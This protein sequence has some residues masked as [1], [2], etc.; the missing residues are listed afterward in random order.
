MPKYYVVAGGIELLPVQ[1]ALAGYSFAVDQFDTVSSELLTHCLNQEFQFRTCEGAN[2]VNK[3]ALFSDKKDAE[4]FSA[5]LSDRA[6]YQELKKYYPI[7]EVEINTEYPLAPLSLKEDNLHQKLPN[8]LWLQGFD[9]GKQLFNG[10]IIDENGS[11]TFKQNLRIVD[12][13]L[14]HY[15]RKENIYFPKTLMEEA[16]RPFPDK[17][18]FL[19]L[20]LT[21]WTV[22]IPIIYTIYRLLKSSDANAALIDQNRGKLADTNRPYKDNIK[23]PNAHFAWPEKPLQKISVIS[24]QPETTF[25]QKV[26]QTLFPAHFEEQEFQKMF[27]HIMIG[28]WQASTPE[29]YSTFK[30]QFS[31]A[32]ENWDP[33]KHRLRVESDPCRPNE[34]ELNPVTGKAMLKIHFQ[35]LDICSGYVIP[36]SAENAPIIRQMIKVNYCGYFADNNGD[37]TKAGNMVTA[38]LET[39]E[40]ALKTSLNPQNQ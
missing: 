3:L 18:F 16:R 5:A 22:I 31:R 35:V 39:I 17:T 37:P 40:A 28:S 21:F 10:Y 7:F 19:W 12:I 14:P 36:V 6:T 23:D 13:D 2:T 24:K 8:H 32:P 27:P 11:K 1:Y 9:A 26:Y 25:G 33:K 38:E 34:E 15:E 30:S 20:G 29:E 4:R